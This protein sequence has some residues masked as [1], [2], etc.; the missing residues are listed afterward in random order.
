MNSARK[1]SDRT[2]PVRE[3]A[4][5]TGPSGARSSDSNDLPDVPSGTW[6][7]APAG[8]DEGDGSLADPWSFRYAASGAHGRIRPGDTV[9]LRGGTYRSEP[10]I[11]ISFSGAPGRPVTWR[12]APGEHFELDGAI[13][14]F[15]DTPGTAWEPVET[16]PGH[17]LYRSTLTYPTTPAGTAATYGGFIQIDGQWLPLATHDHPDEHTSNLD[18]ISSDHHTWRD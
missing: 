14:E 6:I 12:A 4:H 3:V 17:N 9:W 8:R 5:E 15:V 11:T 1:V 18:W 16:R 10:G 2:S 13:P 7:V